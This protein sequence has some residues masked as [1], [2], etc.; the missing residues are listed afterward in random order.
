VDAS[1][2]GFATGT[3]T[4]GVRPAVLAKW[5]G[6]REKVVQAFFASGCSYREGARRLGMNSGSFWRMCQRAFAGWGL[7]YRAL[8]ALEEKKK[9]RRWVKATGNDSAALAAERLWRQRRQPRP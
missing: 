7:Q 1:L 2:L 9:R 8:A 6:A 4:R 5:A 3:N